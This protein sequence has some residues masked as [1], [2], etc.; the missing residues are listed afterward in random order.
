MRAIITIRLMRKLESMKLSNLPKLSIFS[1]LS[2][3]SALLLSVSVS[4]SMIN[5][6]YADNANN[7]T[8]TNILV[9]FDKNYLLKDQA[10]DVVTIKAISKNT[11]L[12]HV[13]N[14]SELNALLQQL[15]GIIN[16]EVINTDRIDNIN[17]TKNKYNYSN[18]SLAT[19]VT[20]AKDT[21]SNR[22][23]HSIINN[24]VNNND[25]ARV[26]KL[27]SI[28]TDVR[29]DCNQMQQD[30]AVL[31][32]L[33]D[34]FAIKLTEIE[35][36]HRQFQEAIDTAQILI[37]LAKINICVDEI[38]VY[39]RQIADKFPAKYQVKD[40][41]ITYKWKVDT[42]SMTNQWQNSWSLVFSSF[43]ETY[44][45]LPGYIWRDGYGTVDD[46]NAHIFVTT[47]TNSEDFINLERYE[48]SSYICLED[49]SLVVSGW[50][51]IFYN[52]NNGAFAQCKAESLRNLDGCIGDVCFP[53]WKNN[54]LDESR[55]IA[56]FNTLEAF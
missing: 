32:D 46:L 55:V 6:C 38:N 12:K 34:K 31:K 16:I 26:H 47:A 8:P 21:N 48:S 45:E 40:K 24:G 3:L 25:D 39:S 15:R 2:T 23:Q 51:S 44:A 7:V 37:L 53:I 1:R 33:Q 56:G 5:S 50:M 20:V 27:F 30:Y 28:E 49:K 9:P 43:Y 10:Y 13:N 4:T 19:R 35:E 17:N 36:L 14:N 52:C 42:G 11:L 41:K 29:I 18:R 54:R 22:I